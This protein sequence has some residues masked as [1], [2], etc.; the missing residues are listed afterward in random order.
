MQHKPCLA[1]SKRNEVARKSKEATK[2]HSDR[3]RNPLDLAHNDTDCGTESINDKISGVPLPGIQKLILERVAPVFAQRPLP[4][5]VKGRTLNQDVAMDASLCNGSKEHRR[6]GN[7]KTKQN[8]GCGSSKAETPRATA[9]VGADVRAMTV[10]QSPQDNG[11]TQG[12][13]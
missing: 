12:T 1:S 10:I 11:A 9:E 2:Y 4:S 7:F 8:L 6:S 5:F 3:G 13:G